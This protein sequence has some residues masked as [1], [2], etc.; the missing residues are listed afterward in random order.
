MVRFTIRVRVRVTVR[1]MVMVRVIVIA[2]ILLVY[3]RSHS[4][5]LRCTNQYPLEVPRSWQKRWVDGAFSVVP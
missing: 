4:R 1:V 2:R 5:V 3:V